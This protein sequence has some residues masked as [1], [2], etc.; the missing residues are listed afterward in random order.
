MEAATR[1]EA[2]C[3]Q[4]QGKVTYNGHAFHEFVPEGTSAYVDQVDNHI[5]GEP[6]TCAS[7]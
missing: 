5:A 3:E 2:W 7:T 6:W 4:V 1:G